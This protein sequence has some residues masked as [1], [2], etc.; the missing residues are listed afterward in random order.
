MRDYGK[1]ITP[2][3]KIMTL[4]A[5]H[6]AFGLAGLSFKFDSLAFYPSEFANQRQANGSI[7]HLEGN[8]HANPAIRRIDSKVQVLDALPDNLNRQAFHGD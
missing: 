8:S 4:A 2:A 5:H 3:K 1:T 6:F 7:I